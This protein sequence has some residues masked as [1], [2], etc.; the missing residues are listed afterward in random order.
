MKARIKFAK[1]GVMKYV[2]HLDIMRYFQ[3][4]MR[5]AQI[6]IK[7]SEGFSPH[8]IMSFAAPLGV[9]ITSEGEYMD[10]EVTEQIASEAALQALNDTM[11]DGMQVLQFVYLPEKCENAMASVKAASYRI[12]YKKEGLC[13]FSEREMQVF[14]R[15]FYTNAAQ[16]MITKKTKK[17]ERT[18]DLKPLIYDLTVKSGEDGQICYDLT[19]ST[20]SVDNIKPEL[21]LHH[22]HRFIGLEVED[23]DLAIHRVDMYTLRDGILVSLIDVAQEDVTANEKESV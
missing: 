14:L 20:G 6:P 15:D 4:A 7:Y 13:T 12:R 1:T 2:G 11:V 9:G 21:V 3:K 16:I 18:L 19:V 17:G 22:F 23:A 5:R 8:Q 10:I